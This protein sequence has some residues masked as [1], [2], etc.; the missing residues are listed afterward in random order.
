MNTAS[1]MYVQASQG[2]CVVALP[3]ADMQGFRSMFAAA[4][5]FFDES[6][7]SSDESGSVGSQRV[8]V[9]AAH[10]VLGTRAGV[11]ASH[12]SKKHGWFRD[13]MR[14][15]YEV[16]QRADIA[17][18]GNLVDSGSSGGGGGGG[19]FE[20]ATWPPCSGVAS[21]GVEWLQGL[22]FPQKP[23]GHRI[24]QLIVPIRATR[25]LLAV[26]DWRGCCSDSRVLEP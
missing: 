5:A 1:N 17:C 13:T 20:N 26:S 10:R 4:A 6:S 3:P 18:S 2:Y 16:H 11:A 12:D 21:D 19:G 23:A 14:E 24:K 7:R 22:P 9:Q 15:Y 8:S 25:L